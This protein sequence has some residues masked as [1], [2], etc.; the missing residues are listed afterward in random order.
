VFV[1][2]VTEAVNG[3]DWPAGTVAAIGE[4]ETDKGPDA[5]L[6]V[7]L[8][9]F[10][11]L[12]LPP[13]SPAALALPLPVLAAVSGVSGDPEKLRPAG[14]LHELTA[15]AQSNEVNAKSFFRASCPR[16]HRYVGAYDTTGLL[17]GFKRRRESARAPAGQPTD[18]RFNKG[19]V[20]TDA[21][22]CTVLP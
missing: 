3:C 4:I 22:I 10:A 21:F 16:R 18:Q 8:L 13:A 20:V 5:P 2:P 12:E 17:S 6:G 1:V 14:P 7:G 15:K 9:A 19:T 11:G